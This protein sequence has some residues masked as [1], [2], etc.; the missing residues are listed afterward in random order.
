MA[1]DLSGIII[2]VERGWHGEDKYING[3]IIE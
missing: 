3:G 1:W 2:R